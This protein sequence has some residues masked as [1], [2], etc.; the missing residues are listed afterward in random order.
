MS[1]IRFGLS[2]CLNRGLSPAASA[3]LV[4]EKLGVEVCEEAVRKWRDAGM[5]IIP[6]DI[7]GD[8]TFE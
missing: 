8:D 7:E 4:R 3:R 5:P 2:I 6:I 1:Q